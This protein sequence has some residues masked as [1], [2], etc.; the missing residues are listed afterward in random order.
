MTTPAEKQSCDRCGACCRQGGP[1][2]HGPDISLIREGRLNR[3]H[4]VT[5]R[6][7]EPA[8]LPFADQPAPVPAEFL[9]LQGR[10]GS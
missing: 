1:A 4:L 6:K 5:I 10:Q 9:K 8:F 2:L 3:Y 7:G